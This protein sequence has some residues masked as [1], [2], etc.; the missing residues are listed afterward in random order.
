[1]NKIQL[2][3]KKIIDDYK[4]I[5][6][7]E[8][9]RFQ[10]GM[11]IKRDMQKDKFSEVSDEIVERALVEY[12]ETLYKLFKIRLSMEALDY[13]NSIQGLRWFAKTFKEFTL[14]GKI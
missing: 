14:P 8:F 3:I 9:S 10:K 7:D 4:R 2:S 13:L 5:Y 12:P 6:P 1:M 11:R